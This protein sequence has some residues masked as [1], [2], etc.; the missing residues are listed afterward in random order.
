M[1]RGNLIEMFGNNDYEVI[2]LEFYFEL[3]YRG[4]SYGF[5]YDKDKNLM[6][7]SFDLEK[8][9]FRFKL[10]K[11]TLQYTKYSYEFKDLRDCYLEGRLIFDGYFVQEEVE[12]IIQMIIMYMWD[13]K[14][15]IIH[16]GYGDML[17]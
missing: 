7:V 13:Q 4:K 16:R 6:K 9:D 5:W 3:I 11:N 8:S 10:N 14:A 1:I 15:V 17:L 12:I 2:E